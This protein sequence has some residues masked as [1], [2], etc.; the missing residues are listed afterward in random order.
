[1][2]RVKNYL[3]KNN[4]SYTLTDRRNSIELVNSLDISK[5]L[6]NLQMPPR[7]YQLRAADIV[8]RSNFGIIRAATGAGKTLIA[9]LITAKLNKPTI[10]YVIGLDLLNQFH[11]FFRRL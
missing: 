1:L 7:D 10:I 2:D 8:E 3:D 11:D 6:E 5:K 9:A 4:L